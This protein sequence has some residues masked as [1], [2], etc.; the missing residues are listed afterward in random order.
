[1]TSL[2]YEEVFEAAAKII[3][4][5]EHS[6]TISLNENTLS[7]RFPTTRRLAEYL[8]IPHYYVLPYFAMMEK[9]GIITRVE[10]VGI[11]TTKKGTRKLFELMATKFLKESKTVL[12][13]A[14]FE[15][16]RRRIGT[17]R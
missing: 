4:L 15:E 6:I 5:E 14:L 16:L 10:R 11:S 9:D 7:I 17:G 12:G 3:L 8:R 2:T 1:M 13:A